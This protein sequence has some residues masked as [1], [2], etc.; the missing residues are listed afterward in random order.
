MKILLIDHSWVVRDRLCRII[1]S[2]PVTVSVAQADSEVAAQL[3]LLTRPP[4]MVV[5]D[6]CLRSGN[7]LLTIAHVKSAY[8]ATSVIVL[9][10]MVYPEYRA[11]CMELG[12]DYFFDKS[13]ETNAFIAQLGKLCAPGQQ[14]SHV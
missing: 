4:M 10:N 1:A 9:T 3:Q 2:L 7:G 5:I 13:K 12:A 8:P 6:P 11:R 14:A